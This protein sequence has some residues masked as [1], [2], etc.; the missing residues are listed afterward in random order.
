MMTSSFNSQSKPFAG[1]ARQRGATLIVGLI[2]MVIISLIVTTAFTLSSSNL[3]SV[4]NLQVR[5]EAIASAQ[6]AIES[7]IS[8][9]FTALPVADEANVDINA[10][11]TTDYVVSFS[12]PVCLRASIAG[13][14][15]GSDVEM[16]TSMSS[17][18]TWNTEWDIDATVSAADGSGATAH[19]REGVRV[20]LSDTQK[21]A[22]C[23]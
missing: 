23:S 22:V 17:A 21:T 18:S 3:K 9:D 2:M 11:G 7:K 5:E 1:L 10:D 6:R 12:V 14:A 13:A 4:G 16:P 15:A 20:L 8:S 19:M